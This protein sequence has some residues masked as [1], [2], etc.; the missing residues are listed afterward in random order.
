MLI[1]GRDLRQTRHGHDFPADRN[2]EVR[3]CCFYAADGLGEGLKIN[4][5]FL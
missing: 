3:S 2:D 1:G 5:G 4:G